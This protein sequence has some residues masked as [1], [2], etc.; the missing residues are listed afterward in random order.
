M[1]TLCMA[2]LSY[3]E[4][5][6]HECKLAVQISR[7][8]AMTPGSDSWAKQ[9]LTVAVICDVRHVAAP[10]TPQ[11]L[12]FQPSEAHLSAASLEQPS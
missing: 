7:V 5:G 4:A 8:Q 9:R 11:A 2:A 10:S 1:S 3:R 6:K 12:V